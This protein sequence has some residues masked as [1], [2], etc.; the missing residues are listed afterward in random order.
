M[1]VDII[2]LSAWQGTV[3]WD[4]VEDFCLKSNLRGAFVKATEGGTWVDGQFS[5]NF[6]EMRRVHLPYRGAYLFLDATDPVGQ[7]RH[8]VDVLTPFLPLQPG[9]F[10]VYDWE[11]DPNGNVMSASDVRVAAAELHK[12]FTH[13]LE[14]SAEWV[15]G[16][17]VIDPLILGGP[18]NSTVIPRAVNLG[19]VLAQFTSSGTVPGV[20][21]N[22][23]ESQIVDLAAFTAVIGGD[24]TPQEFCALVG[25]ELNQDGVA[26]VGHWDGNKYPLAKVWAWDFDED[27]NPNNLVARIVAAVV[28]AIPQPAVTVQVDPV[29]IEA[30]V[31]AVL[32]GTKL[33]PS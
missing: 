25:A 10:A 31:K 18:Y 5:R 21:G 17:T 29:A 1:N 12:T 33:V 7:V 2:D 4:Q 20:V 24:M 32:V 23:D 6:S 13:V 27:T 15:P 11:R 19:A 16:F 3:N 30:A 8:F 28:K 22:V 9:E 14:Y 26:V